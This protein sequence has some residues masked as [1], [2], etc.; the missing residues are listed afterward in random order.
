MEVVR[1]FNSTEE[2]I[3]F[4]NQSKVDEMYK[5]AIDN[6]IDN[7]VTKEMLLEAITKV[8]DT[9]AELSILEDLF[10]QG[11]VDKKEV[12]QAKRRNTQARNEVENLY[13]EMGCKS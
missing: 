13:K 5:E 6:A 4:I 1:T 11:K 7:Q 9:E 8:A 2:Y 12:T 10:I 3:N